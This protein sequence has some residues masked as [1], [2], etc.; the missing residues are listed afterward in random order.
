MLK[1]SDFDY[2]LPKNLI[3]SRPH[4]PR[5][6]C[7]LLVYNRQEK[8]IKHSR[9]DKILDFLKAGDILVLNNT[10]VIP[11][12]LIGRRISETENLGRRFKVLL[13]RQKNNIWEALIDGKNRRIGLKIDFGKGLRGEIIKWKGEGIWEIKFNKRGKEL[14]NLIFKLGKMPLPPYIKPSFVKASEGRQPSV[15]T[16]DSRHKT[17]YQTVYAKY[18]GSVAAPTAGLHFTRRLLQRLKRKGVKIVF[19]TLHV[20]LG[21]FMPV[22]VENITEHKMQPEYVEIST[23]TAAILNKAKKEGRRIIAVGTTTTRALEAVAAQCHAEPTKCHAELVSASAKFQNSEAEFSVHYDAGKSRKTL[24]MIKPFKGEVNLFIYPSYKFKFIDGLITN[25]HLPKS[26][27]L[28]MT[29][30]FLNQNPKKSVNLIKKI[31]QKA[32]KKKYKFYS[33]G[34][35]MLI[36]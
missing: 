31:Y 13:L 34:D 18:L 29:A 4:S 8:Q 30:A 35:A 25:F 19:L 32:I 36:L 2:K 11:A 6:K 17:W 14:E 21:T 23:K 33:Y 16:T 24:P 10:K 26:T 27:L 28:M 20:G 22:R 7:K 15:E 1:L 3:A 5:D 12:R 9:F